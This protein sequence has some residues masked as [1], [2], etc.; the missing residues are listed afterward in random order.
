MRMIE[1]V[2]SGKVSPIALVV[3]VPVT[4]YNF[5]SL[6]FDHPLSLQDLIAIVLKGECSLRLPQV[7]KI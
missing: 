3:S 2:W 5:L 4:L 1:L 6:D 7:F